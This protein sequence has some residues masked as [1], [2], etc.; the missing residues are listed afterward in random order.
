MLQLTRKSTALYACIFLFSLELVQVVSPLLQS[1]AKDKRVAATMLSMV[2][3][4]MPIMLLTYTVS[5]RES[6]ECNLTSSN[7]RQQNVR[8][9]QLSKQPE[10][11]D[12]VAYV[13]MCSPSIACYEAGPLIR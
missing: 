6:E 5:W 11:F 3:V 9:C 8:M 12:H 10:T 7:A 4:G 13:R 1:E 2:K